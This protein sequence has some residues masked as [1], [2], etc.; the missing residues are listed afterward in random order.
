LVRGESGLG[1]SHLLQA[2]CHA[3]DDALYLPLSELL[4]MPPMALLEGTEGAA[5]LA[6]DELQA[7]EGHRDWQEA[8]FHLYNRAQ[9]SH[10][11]LVIASRSAPAQISELLPDLRSR[12]EQLPT[13]L[14]PRFSE[15]ELE[16]LL[17][18]RA[19]Q[20]GLELS[21]EVRSYM[22]RRGPRDPQSLMALLERLD[23]AAL[24]L[25]RAITIPLLKELKLLPGDQ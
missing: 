7:I 17:G 6:L 2:L 15:A 14:L 12:L 1:K 21:A 19:G 4:D 10:T 20:R 8:L 22:L 23:Q 11:R 13:F 5:V 25:Q 3:A 24:A 9:Q 16:A 18:L